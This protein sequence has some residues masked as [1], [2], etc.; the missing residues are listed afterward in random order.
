MP[1]KSLRLIKQKLRGENGEITRQTVNQFMDAVSKHFN[2]I[3]SLQDLSLQYGTGSF[4]D[5]LIDND[6]DDGEL[7]NWQDQV[8]E[9][10]DEE[11]ANENKNK[12]PVRLRD[13]AQR[14][15]IEHY[16]DSGAAMHTMI[17]LPETSNAE[18]L[19]GYV[20][21]CEEEV[22]YIDRDELIEETCKKWTSSGQGHKLFFT[23]ICSNN[24]PA[25]FA[26][27]YVYCNLN[28]NEGPQSPVI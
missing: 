21:L 19:D 27:L 8:N 7:Q 6:G 14:I 22:G 20:K 13:Y 16:W 1:P 9:L 17:F 15:V 4:W 12:L 11:T 2:F 18:R 5:N 3:P 23:S 26:N 28:Q 10:M 24:V 25:L